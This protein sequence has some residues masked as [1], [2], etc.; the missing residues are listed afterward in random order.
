MNV[1]VFFGDATPIFECECGARCFGDAV[2]DAFRSWWKHVG[3]K[4]PEAFGG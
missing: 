4:H 3:D 1:R 2:V